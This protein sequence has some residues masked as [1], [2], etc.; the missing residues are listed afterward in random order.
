VFLGELA[1]F[2]VAKEQASNHFFASRN[3][4]HSQVAADGQMSPRHSEV[5][6][7]LS[8]AGIFG[9]VVDAYGAFATE[10]GAEKEGVPRHSELLEL[11]AG[12]AG[13][14]I[15]SVILAPF[16]DSVVKECAELSAGDVGSG[17]S[18]RLHQPPEVELPCQ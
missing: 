4:R 14:G 3:H 6:L 8:V 2:L 11:L 5:W 16:V 9:D 1:R 10:R 13:N 17:I 12:R 7:A 18:D 15:Q